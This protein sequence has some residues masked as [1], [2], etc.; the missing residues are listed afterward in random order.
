MQNRL[1][2]RQI[3]KSFGPDGPS[4]PATLKF[5]QMVEDAYHHFEMTREL[6]DRTMEISAKDLELKNQALIEV[7]EALD[8]FTHG[9]SHDLRTHA[10]NMN[11]MVS[12]LKKHREL[13]NEDKIDEI[14]YHLEQTGEA[15]INIIRGFLDVSRTERELDI[16]PENINIKDLI[17][18][19]TKEFEYDLKQIKA[20][21]EINVQIPQMMFPKD[22]L[23]MVLRNLIGNCIKYRRQKVPLHIKVCSCLKND[24][25]VIEILDNGKGIDLKNKNK[26]LFKM[27]NRFETDK[28]IEGSGIGLFMVKKILSKSGATIKIESE[29][30]AWT[31]CILTFSK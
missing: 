16:E 18:S 4:D 12:M 24:H 14:I 30:G 27:F 22:R 2:A 23:S 3:K 25:L 7:N 8:D 1:L 28:N 19:V 20:V 11:S 15:Y 17:E 6:L 10:V 26:K 5:I 31:K 21:V 9:I 29:H 13:K